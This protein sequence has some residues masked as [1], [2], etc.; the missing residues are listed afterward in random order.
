MPSKISF[1][2]DVFNDVYALA[3]LA[4]PRRR[5]QFFLQLILVILA[6]ASELLSIGSVVPFLG[7][8]TEPDKV[9]QLPLMQPLITL[10]GISEPKQLLFPLTVI[11]CIAVVLAATLRLLLLWIT[12]RLSFAF[13]ADIS[14]K[15][16]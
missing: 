16:L 4:S 7:A 3:K 5:F 9:F 14:I 15:Y 11:F 6:S 1:K 8:I 2:L 10:M 13:G 12:T